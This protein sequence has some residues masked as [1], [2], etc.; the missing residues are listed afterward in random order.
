MKIKRI[1]IKNFR[2]LRDVLMED[3]GD[4]S[5]LIGGNSS[6][7]TTLLESLMLFFNE[8]DPAPERNIGGIN[9]YL[10]FDRNY[11]DPIEFAVTIEVS[12]DKIETILHKEVLKSMVLAE[13]NTITLVREI[14]GTPTAATWRTKEVRVNDAPLIKNGKLV[15]KFKEKTEEAPPP[16][17]EAPPPPTPPP[18]PPPADVVGRI[19]QNV[20]QTLKGK[21]KLIFAARNVVGTPSRLGDRISFIQSHIISELTTLGQSLNR[22]EEI[23]WTEIEDSV[24]DAS[25]NI[26]DLRIIGG[27]ITIREEESHR[28]FPISLVGG[29]HQ[30]ILALIHQL[31]K[32]ENGIFGIEE[33]EL[34]SHPQLARQLFDAL[35]EVSREKQI[36]I[37]THSTVFVDQADLTNTWIVRKENKETKVIRIK[38]PKDLKNVLYELGVRPSDIFYSNGIIFV[39]GPPE[40]VVFPILAEKMGV[41]F[42][43]LGVSL[44]PTRGKSKGKY[45]LEVWIEAS[46]NVQIPY[47]MVLDKDATGEAKR[48]IKKVY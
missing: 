34:H 45:H 17:E 24:K 41:D 9:D 23:K 12:K 44:I 42:R 18:P 35:K 47:F 15:Y 38:E 6:G 31:L 29:G 25:P 16:P 39:E 1:H 40:K 33:P 21:F 22:P 8:L 26:Q 19:L 28:R 20:S 32:E 30:E 11:K 48:Y 43:Q 46:K 5:I 2:S 4:F 13:A 36:F 37:T 10:W 14:S 7:K 27:Q 3:I